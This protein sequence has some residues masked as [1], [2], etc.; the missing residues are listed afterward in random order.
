MA[1][2]DLPESELRSYRPM[3]T[4][5]TDFDEF[6]AETLFTAR[7]AGDNV[8]RT[9]V[10]TAITL[11]DVEDIVFPDSPATPSEPGSSSPASGQSRPP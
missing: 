8:E 11:F 9:R 10:D 1:R 3:I 6:W 2:F 4:E 5:P 7:A